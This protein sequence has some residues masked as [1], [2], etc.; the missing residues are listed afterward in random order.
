MNRLLVLCFLVPGLVFAQS[1]SEAESLYGDGDLKLA[2]KMADQVLT[3][4]SDARETG[5]L[6][7]LR[8]LV[9]L[10]QGKKDK[11]RAAFV[12]A[13]QA[14]GEVKLDKERA[15]PAALALFDEA[16]ESVPP[17]SV[18]V[19][20][21]LS[22][23][24]LRI[25]GADFGPLPLTTKLTIGRHALEAT[26]A[27]GQVS[28]AEVL[29]KSGQA[30]TVQLDMSAPVDT[31]RQVA[32]LVPPPLS[33]PVTFTEPP[34]TTSTGSATLLDE[35]VPRAMMTWWGLIPLSVIAIVGWMP[36]VLFSAEFTAVYGG[37]TSIAA[38]G[39]VG[40]GVALLVGS[41]VHTDLVNGKS[42]RMELWGLI[43]LGIGF[44]AAIATFATL[45]WLDP[46]G[47]QGAAITFASIA[48]L[49][50]GIGGGMLIGNALGLAP[51]APKVSFFALP[52]GGGG[53]TVVGRF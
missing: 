24:T 2:L 52:Q 3:R 20:T 27:D 6:Q 21:T 26:G 53:L 25:D 41:A 18:E 30:Q 38:I 46:F 50:L 29:V 37:L 22:R 39:L 49:G 14:D 8:G 47:T 16:R 1:L 4:T 45:P 13:L 42:P 35:P 36:P 15:P 32:T 31:G 40:L 44:A 48:I 11:A 43:P 34:F 12:L 9:L 28:R 19:S 23:A 17:G 51:T 33:Q 5:R 7:V 10:A